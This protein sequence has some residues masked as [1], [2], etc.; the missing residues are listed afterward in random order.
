M[1]ITCAR[2][3]AQGEP[4]PPHRV[5]FTGPE[6]DKVLES[7]CGSCYK[8]WEKVEIKVINEY[9]LSFM[10]PQHREVLK[11]ATLD[12]LFGQKTPNL[13]E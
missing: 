9:R 7:I 6:K 8:E 10:D 1:P 2:C 3:G 4:P 11:Q 5:G 12:F 13:P